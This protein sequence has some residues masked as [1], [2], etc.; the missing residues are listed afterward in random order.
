MPRLRISSTPSTSIS[1]PVLSNAR[2]RLANSSGYSTLAGSDTRSRANA[3][4]SSTGANG[5]K[6]ERAAAEKATKEKAA[7]EKAAKEQAD[8]QKTN[9]DA[10]A[11]KAKEEAKR[12]ED[13]HSHSSA[14][15]IRC[16]RLDKG[17]EGAY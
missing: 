12:L 17:S 2:T 5:S 1:R 8:K 11:K 10:D 16:L 4:P 9:K 6:R 7:K 14:K 3:T 15:F 13:I